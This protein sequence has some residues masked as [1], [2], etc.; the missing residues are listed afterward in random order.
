MFEFLKNLFGKSPAD[1]EV[2]LNTG[3]NPPVIISDPDLKANGRK[4]RWTRK[5]GENFTFERLNDLDQAYF[6]DQSINM[7]R[8]KISCK[9]RAP[10]TG[11]ADKYPYEIVVKWNGDE[12]NSTKEGAPGGGKPVIRN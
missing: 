8:T 11:D 2:S 5:E 6:N 10:D 12:Y 3:L 4:I 1:L 7:A 9:N